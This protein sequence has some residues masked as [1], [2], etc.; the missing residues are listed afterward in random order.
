MIEK[1]RWDLLLRFFRS[2]CVRKE[3]LRIPSICHRLIEKVYVTDAVAVRVHMCEKRNL[4]NSTA[5]PPY[6]SR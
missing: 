2:K 6:V 3:L 1:T 5:S 4:I